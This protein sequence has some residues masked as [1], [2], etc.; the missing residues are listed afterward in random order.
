MSK[1]RGIELGLFFSF[2][3]QI[4]LRGL[5]FCANWG[6][7]DF[8]RTKGLIIIVFLWKGFTVLNTCEPMRSV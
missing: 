3:N 5:G 4:S 7:M 1:L 6:S 2:S 8:G